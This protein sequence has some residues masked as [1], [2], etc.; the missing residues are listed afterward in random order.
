M[1]SIHDFGGE[2]L[3]GQGGKALPPIGQF[4]VGT[5]QGIEARVP[6]GSYPGPILANLETS[7]VVILPNHKILMDAFDKCEIGQMV[8]LEYKGKHSSGRYDIWEV[9]A[10]ESDRVK[11]IDLNSPLGVVV[12]RSEAWFQSVGHDPK[13]APWEGGQ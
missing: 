4:I 7:L 1:L 10:I 6:A 11:K 8:V 5:F 9:A 3:S 12:K 13:A 2:M